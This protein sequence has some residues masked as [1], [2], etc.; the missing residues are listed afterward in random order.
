MEII[1][2]HQAS[3][4]VH[5]VERVA[6][7]LGGSLLAISGIRQGR[8]GILRMLTGAA[9][10]ARGATG[11]CQLYQALGVRTA[12]TGKNTSIPYELGVRARAAITVNY[13]RATLYEFWRHLE[14]LPRFMRHLDSVE[15][16]DS[17]RSHWVAQ[18]PANSKVEWDAEIINEI[19][20]ELLAWRS[21]PGSDVDSAGSVRFTDAPGN[22][23]TEIRVELQY[24]PP[25]GVLGAYFARLF[26]RE[27]EQEIEAD[28]GRLKQ[29]LETGEVATTK[30]QPKGTGSNV[31]TREKTTRSSRPVLEGVIA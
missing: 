26:G 29:Y 28:L 8:S 5:P 19:P 1:H 22:R 9:M 14:N 6:S 16:Q 10:I 7:V 13:P 11:H 25:A 2:H 24:N 17:S 15:Q 27:P 18:G 12:P 21:L 23:G 30:G 4:N 3:S 31:H 20:G